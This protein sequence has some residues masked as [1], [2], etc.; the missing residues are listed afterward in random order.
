M[1]EMCSTPCY[2]GTMKSKT[3]TSN[4]LLMG[5]AIIWGCAFVPQKIG[6]DSIGPFWFTAIRFTIGTI[7]ILPLLYLEKGTAKLTSK[8]WMKGIA[9]GVILFGGINLQQVAL[10]YASVANTGFITGLYVALVPLLCLFTG[11]RHGAGLWIGV[12]LAVIGLYLLSVHGALQV[13]PGDLLTLLSSLFWALQVI[14]LSSFCHSLPP[15]KLAIIQSGTCLL[16]SLVLA[17]F[18]EPISGQMVRDAYIPLLYGSVMSV[19][20]GFTLQILAQRHIK[21]AHSAIILSTE[22]VIAAV[23]AWAIL[24]ETLG[25]R[26]ILGC[27]LILAGTLIAQFS[28][29]QLSASPVPSA[30]IKQVT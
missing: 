29:A 24:G 13:N 10:I 12:I 19:A 11:Q 7:L 30:E 23:A 2:V 28:G 25:A 27:I 26:E 5:A 14:A 15:I 17:L 3:I 4:V 16:M 9:V 20:V 6:M 18:V 1:F 21:A 8:D 22:S